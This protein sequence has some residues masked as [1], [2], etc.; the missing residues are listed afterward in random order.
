MRRLMHLVEKD[1]CI[2]C[3]TMI[4]SSLEYLGCYRVVVE[5][6]RNSSAQLV[7]RDKTFGDLTLGIMIDWPMYKTLDLHFRF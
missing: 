7:N 5:E 6:I 4:C 1:V 2:A 3:G